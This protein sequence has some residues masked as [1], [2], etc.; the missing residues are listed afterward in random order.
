MDK[1]M[2]L[3]SCCFFSGHGI[4]HRQTTYTENPSVFLRNYEWKHK[5][6]REANKFGQRIVPKKLPHSTET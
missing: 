6:T 1:A 2:I 3:L 5:G 4:F